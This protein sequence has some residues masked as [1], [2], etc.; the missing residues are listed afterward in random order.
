MKVKISSD[1]IHATEITGT[2]RNRQ[3]NIKF[4]SKD[5]EDTSSLA[6]VAVQSYWF[7]KDN[8]QY[9]PNSIQEAELQEDGTVIILM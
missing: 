7:A 9:A 5:G 1:S 6:R 8:P 2:K 4:L 3:F